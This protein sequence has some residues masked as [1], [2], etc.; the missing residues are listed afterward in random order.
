MSVEGYNF[1]HRVYCIEDKNGIFSDWRYFDTNENI[2][3]SPKRPCIS[4]G[5]YQTEKDHDPC[6]ANLKNVDFAC[7]GHG[8]SEIGSNPYIKES[9]GK[10]TRFESREK[11]I[12]YC[13]NN[14]LI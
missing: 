4:C 3:D 9:N 6:I 8:L 10:V 13:R 5:L 7:C 12:E 2:S 11:L 1:G 14:S